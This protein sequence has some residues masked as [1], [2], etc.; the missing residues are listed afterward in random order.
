MKAERDAGADPG[1]EKRAGRQ[2]QVADA[3]LGTT[4]SIRANYQRT[5]RMGG[6]RLCAADCVAKV[7]KLQGNLWELP[8]VFFPNQ[9]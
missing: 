7:K 1:V 3:Q 2:K 6:G 9:K 5:R 8:S 4:V